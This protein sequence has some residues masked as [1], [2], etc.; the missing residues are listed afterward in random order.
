MI[1]VKGMQPCNLHALIMF[2]DG[3]KGYVHH[4]FDT[5]MVILH[6]G[7]KTVRV[8]STC[9]IQ[10]EELVTKVG[11]DFIGRVL[12]LTGEPLDGKGPIAADGVL[13]VFSPAPM[14]YE[15]ELL[16]KP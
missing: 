4:I 8:G 3:S 2:E 16:D 1:M 6:L 14:L 15:R 9:V 5:H 7:T 10:Y 12:S 11:M 13:P